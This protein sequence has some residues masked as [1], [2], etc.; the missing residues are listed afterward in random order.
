MDLYV[1][2]K[3]H[4]FAY[5]LRTLDQCSII[6]WNL[7][8]C[9]KKNLVIYLQYPLA[10]VVSLVVQFFLV[11]APQRYVTEI[12]RCFSRVQTRNVCKGRQ[13]LLWHAFGWILLE[14]QVGGIRFWVA[15]FDNSIFRAQ[16]SFFCLTISILDSITVSCFLQQSSSFYP[17]QL[18]QGVGLIL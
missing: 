7:V 9:K 16:F 8:L 3:H 17:F 18:E 14:D 2:P 12:L 13:L 1:N 10:V 6:N 4:A 11:D 5:F 15:I